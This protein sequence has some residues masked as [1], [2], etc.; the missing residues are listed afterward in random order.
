MTHPWFWPRY[1]GYQDA[2]WFDY[3]REIAIEAPFQITHDE[4][5]FVT[6]HFHR[7]LGFYTAA[8]AK[9][10]LDSFQLLEPAP[11]P[12]ADEKYLASWSTPRIIAGAAR[13]R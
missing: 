12:R 5:D 1:W 11:D 7:P 2:K 6:T 4:T 13:R 10:D 9:A 8:M 3:D